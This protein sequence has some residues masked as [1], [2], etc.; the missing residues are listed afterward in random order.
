[1]KRDKQYFCPDMDKQVTHA[2][3]PIYST[4]ASINNASAEKIS[5]R[6]T[7][8]HLMRPTSQHACQVILS[9]KG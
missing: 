7:L 5:S 8:M 9:W 2:A 3:A 6:L 4:R 1:M